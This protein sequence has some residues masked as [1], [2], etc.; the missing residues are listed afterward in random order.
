LYWQVGES[1]EQNQCFKMALTK[2]KQYLVT[3]K[4]TTMAWILLLIK[5]M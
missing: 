4:T 5:E 3:K 1:S 2:A